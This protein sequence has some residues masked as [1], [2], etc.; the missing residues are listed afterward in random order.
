[1]AWDFG[2]TKEEDAYKQKVAAFLDKELT[3]EIARQN[4][5]DLGLGDEGRVFG[6]KLYEAGLLGWSWPVEFGGKG[7][8]PIYD[9]ILI[10][11]LGKRWSAHVPNDVAYTMVG[12]TILRRGNDAMKK[13]FIP[14]IVR[15]EIE[16]GLGYTEPEAGSDLANMKMTAI[17]Q[18]DFYLV[19]GQKTFNTESHYSD[20]HWLAVKTD[21][22]ASPYKGISLFIVDQRAPGSRSGP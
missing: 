20:Y 9:F 8:S 2:Y 14:R 19:N 13:E 17:D 12:H 16:F 10:D 15:G 18:G 21:L 22:K 6:K 5:E 4:W 11:E 7:L 3:E 1:M